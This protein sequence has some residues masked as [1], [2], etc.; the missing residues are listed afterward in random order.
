MKHILFLVSFLFSLSLYAGNCIVPQSIE[1]PLDKKLKLNCLPNAYFLKPAIQDLSIEN[2]LRGPSIKEITF[3]SAD[4][5]YCRYFYRPQNGSS[6][7]FRCYRTN[8]KNEFYNDKGILIPEAKSVG[9]QGEL[10]E[11]LLNA[12]GEAI[13]NAKGKQQKADILKVRF[14]NGSNRHRENFASTLA[15]RLS[16][17]MG[18]PMENYY[19]VSKITC[20]GCEKNPWNEGKAPQK[21]YKP[22]IQ[23]DFMYASIER[24]YEA[25]RIMKPSEKYQNV[26]WNWSEFGANIG[27]LTQ[28]QRVEFE[29]LALV[30]NFLQVMEH[31]GSQHVVLCEDEYYDKTTR[32]CSQALAAIHD[33]GSAFGN[34]VYIDPA[35]NNHPRAD[36]RGYEKV[37]MFKK[38]EMGYNKT[39]LTNFLPASFVEFNA[40]LKLINADIVKALLKEAYFQ[41]ADL[42]F[43]AEIKKAN[44]KLT[45]EQLNELIIQKWTDLIMKK[46]QENLNVNC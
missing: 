13:L 30:A 11:V 27:S 22:G 32:I 25:K 42:P 33:M 10:E 24:K 29:V 4:T 23:N 41:Y 18:V 17:I 43:R 20:F 15:S 46:V 6:N 34:R 9:T 19:S 45:E 5:V 37:V 40:R 26:P 14:Q 21:I 16:W 28:K 39:G 38:C 44:P 1:G 31:R 12:Q 8:E 35:S 36:F 7:K 3:K 2:I